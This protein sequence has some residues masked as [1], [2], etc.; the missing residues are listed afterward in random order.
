MHVVTNWDIESRS[1]FARNAYHPDAGDRIAFAS[2]SLRAISYTADR[3][4]FLGRNGSLARPAALLRQ[5]LSG[6]SG[7]GFDPCAALHV[8][9]EIDPGQDAEVTFCLGQAA[10]AAQAR[11]LVRQ[12][13]SPGW[14]DS[15]LQ[16]T[17][18][19]WD[20]LLETI[21]VETPDQAVNFMLNRWLLYQ[22]LSCR[23]WGRS[24]SQHKT[25]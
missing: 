13:Q 22:T 10:G 17:R 25:S 14:V 3:A 16:A 23:V 9:V 19:W 24:A 11:N 5:S 7:A 18:A 12:F 1:V 15:S 20:Q 4:E 21:Q 6:R 8:V 2:S